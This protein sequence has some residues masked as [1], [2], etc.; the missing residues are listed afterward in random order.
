M[1]ERPTP[2]RQ[3]PRLNIGPGVASSSSLES[4]NG[5]SAGAPK[6]WPTAVQPWSPVLEPELKILSVHA[7]PNCTVSIRSDGRALET[8]KSTSVATCP[9]LPRPRFLSRSFPLRLEPKLLCGPRQGTPQEAEDDKR[10]KGTRWAPRAGGSE[11]ETMGVRG[12]NGQCP[13]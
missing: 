8:A 3:A 4:D 6:P 11:M 9:K 2:P 5:A 10:P 7:Q 12:R 13:A 1:K